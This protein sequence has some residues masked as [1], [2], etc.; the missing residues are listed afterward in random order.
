MLHQISSNTI[1]SLDPDTKRIELDAFV[2]HTKHANGSASSYLRAKISA[3]EKKYNFSS[4]EL[5]KKLSKGE[6]EETHE[7][8]SWLFYIDALKTHGG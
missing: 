4:V 6:I 7:I 1:A 3:F 8:A 5:G 2:G